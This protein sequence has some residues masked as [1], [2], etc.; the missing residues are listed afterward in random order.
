MLID[1]TIL[2]L[3]GKDELMTG[4]FQENVLGLGGESIYLASQ[5]HVPSSLLS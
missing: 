2:L 4:S 1:L 5:M 3:R